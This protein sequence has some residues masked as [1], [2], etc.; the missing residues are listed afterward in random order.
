MLIAATL[1]R[2]TT[3]LHGYAERNG[4]GLGGAMVFLVPRD[5]ARHD[6]YRRDQTSTDGSFTLNRVIPGDYTVVAIE[7]GWTLDW[8]R[9]EVLAPYAAGGIRVRVTG[10]RTLDLPTYVEVQ[11]R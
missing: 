8:G 9:P 11:P 4:K 1:A 5:P 6:L 10:Q 3:A 7:N 2:G